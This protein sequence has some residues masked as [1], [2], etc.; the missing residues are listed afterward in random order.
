MKRHLILILTFTFLSPIINGYSQVKVSNSISPENWTTEEWNK[1]RA[2]GT[3]TEGSAT[4]SR[5]MIVNAGSPEASYAGFKILEN[6]GSAMDAVITAALADITL[7]AGQSV[8]FAGFTNILYY[9]AEEQKVYS[10]NAG[11]NTPLEENDPLSIP[12]FTS[13][14]PS[15]RTALVPG[16]MKGIEAGHQKFGKLPFK[17]LFEASIFFAEKGIEVDPRLAYFIQWQQEYIG[18]LDETKSIFTNDDG[19]WLKVGDTLKQRALAN[20][21]KKVALEGSRYMYTG[22]W[23]KKFVQTI[24][25]EGGFLSLKDLKDYQVIWD[26][27]IHTGYRDFEVYGVAPPTMGGV[28]IIE[29]LNVL[30]QKDLKALGHYTE[31]PETLF[32]LL[33]SARLADL[34]GTSFSANP[35]KESIKRKYIPTVS[36]DAKVRTTQSHAEDLY[37][38]MNTNAWNEMIKEANKI[39]SSNSNGHSDAIV[40][41]DAEGN[42]AAML[43]TCNTMLWGRT[44]IFVDGVSIPD[45]GS[46]NQEQMKKV[47]PGSRLEESTSSLIVLKDKK[48]YAVCSSISMGVHEVTLQNTVNMLDF[49][50]DPFTA[51]KTPHFAPPIL[52]APGP[53]KVAK[54]FIKTEIEPEGPQVQIVVE[55]FFDSDLLE[56]VR[57]KGEPIQEVPREWFETMKGMWIGILFDPERKKLFGTTIDDFFGS[58]NSN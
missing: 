27:P 44:G 58:A 35:L 5:Y 37:K 7:K 9:N 4:G 41:I 22:D 46:G 21:L 23:A 17:T 49:G 8:S 3:G 20:T 38:Q 57:S 55:N 1:A 56:K 29:A 45:A 14:K 43:H 16:F 39:S 42:M 6:G 51:N 30:K 33:R 36:L 24:E 11:W 26:E 10:L 52:Q 2:Y 40:A 50:M 47:G 28:N 53:Y 15:G 18:R 13:G 31:S 48:P 34:F 25:R 12:S 54:E 32:L 19:E